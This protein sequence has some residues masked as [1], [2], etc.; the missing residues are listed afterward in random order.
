MATNGR[1]ESLT[2]L[3][4]DAYGTLFDVFSVTALCEELFPARGTGLA[5]LW[6]AKQL[7]YSLL[8]SLMGRHRNF[9]QLTEDSLVYACR[10]LNLELLPDRRRR[11]MNAYL[12]LDAFPDARP[13][14]EL[15]KQQGLRLAVLSNGEPTMLK[16]ACD[17]ARLVPLLDA[18]ISAEDAGVFKP[19]PRIYNLVSERLSVAVPHIGFV[20]SNS[21]D[22]AGAASA[23]LT[24]FWIRRAAAEPE[25]ELG[26]PAVHVVGALTE[27]PALLQ[28]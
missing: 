21:W 16:A 11:L 19:S 7:H 27:L 3:A 9:W 14:L 4:F 22:I 12:T 15:L 10:S 8:R 2:A 6:R 17:H 18:T 13:G 5:Q 23:G 20:S 24:T 25:E 28:G 26:F 1:P